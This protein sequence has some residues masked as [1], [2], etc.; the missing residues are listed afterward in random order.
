[1]KVGEDQTLGCCKDESLVEIQIEV[2]RGRPSYSDGYH[3]VPTTKLSLV[4]RGW[5]RLAMAHGE[6]SLNLSIWRRTISHNQNLEESVER[7]GG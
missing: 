6:V 5:V 3:P 7:H 2:R 1:M 4:P